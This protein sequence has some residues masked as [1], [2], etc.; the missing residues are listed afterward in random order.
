VPTIRRPD[1]L[2]R[3]LEAI[4][5]DTD[6]G[7][8]QAAAATLATHGLGRTLRLVL[9]KRCIN[10]RWWR[11]HLAVQVCE[12]AFEACEDA[13]DAWHVDDPGRQWL[14]V[15]GKVLVHLRAHMHRRLLRRA[16]SALS[17]ALANRR[18]E[19]SDAVDLELAVRR[20]GGEFLAQSVCLLEGA[21][22]PRDAQGQLRFHDVGDAVS[23]VASEIGTD[24]TLIG[25][26]ACVRLIVG[27]AEGLRSL[28]GDSQSGGLSPLAI[29]SDFLTSIDVALAKELGLSLPTSTCQ[30]ILVEAG[31]LDPALIDGHAFGADAVEAS[32]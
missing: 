13:L 12:A 19:A 20:L 30:M 11:H 18:A 31:V 3:L 27:L 8:A 10:E 16:I 24:V 4:V 2:W 21:E 1:D 23:F 26:D 14:W 15:A 9:G 32:R 22:M 17:R 25:L 29:C 5:G 6:L 28:L 7:A